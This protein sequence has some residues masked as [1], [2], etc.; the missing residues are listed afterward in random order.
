MA[1]TLRYGVYF[2]PVYGGKAHLRSYAGTAE[3]SLRQLLS[4]EEIH[5]I[6]NTEYEDVTPIVC[7]R[8]LEINQRK[9]R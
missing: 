1:K 5:I 7:R 8:C 6:A 3:C 4:K 2:L 9:E